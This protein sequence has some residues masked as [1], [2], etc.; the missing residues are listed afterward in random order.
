VNPFLIPS[1]VN[2][3]T[4]VPPILELA[5]KY[6][7][8]SPIATLKLDMDQEISSALLQCCICIHASVLQ[9]I[10]DQQQRGEIMTLLSLPFLQSLKETMNVLV[11]DIQKESP[12]PNLSQRHQ[13][14]KEIE[15]GVAERI[16]QL[17]QLTF[18]VGHKKLEP[19]VILFLKSLSATSPLISTVLQINETI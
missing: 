17:T 6:S 10:F 19:D 15:E 18:G 14:L 12:P 3:S 11:Q 8:L 1:P 9:A 7:V 5:I 2:F 4:E 13:L 16:A